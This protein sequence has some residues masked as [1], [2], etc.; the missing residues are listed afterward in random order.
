MSLVAQQGSRV[1]A[2]PE[3]IAIATFHVHGRAAQISTL[4]QRSHALR[5]MAE[6][7]GV[8]DGELGSLLVREL[9]QF[10]RLL[11]INGEGCFHIDV[12]AVLQ[13]ESSNLEVALRGRCYVHNN[14][15]AYVQKCL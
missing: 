13:A 9:K 4:N 6:L 15:S 7:R 12:T 2:S 11:G 8:S 5:R 1:V 3:V 10:L 14:L